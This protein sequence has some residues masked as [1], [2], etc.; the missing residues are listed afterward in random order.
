LIIT[1]NY[2][3]SPLNMCGIFGI[4]GN[5]T[6]N[7]ARSALNTL[8][9]RGPD[10]WGEYISQDKRIY[11][12][13]RRLSIIDLSAGKQPIYNEQKDKVIIF[14]TFNINPFII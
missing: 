6:E 11:L 8:I 7:D 4:Y 9:H 13:H 2:T 12:G 10:E 5:F 14:K 1:P 3:K